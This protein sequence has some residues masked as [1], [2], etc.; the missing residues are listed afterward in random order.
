MGH[1]CGDNRTDV[2]LVRLDL[3]ANKPLPAIGPGGNRYRKREVRISFVPNI[4]TVL[5]GREVRWRRGPRWPGWV[6]EDCGRL[7]AGLLG[8][9]G[10]EVGE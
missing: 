5:C 7:L 6:G 3:C 1:W 8:L 9:S 4:E 10:L 2:T